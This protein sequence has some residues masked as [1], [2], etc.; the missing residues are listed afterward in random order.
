MAR[1]PVVSNSSAATTAA[2][3]SQQ[4]AISGTSAAGSRVRIAPAFASSH[5]KKSASAITP[6]LTT[7]ASPPANSRSGS[8]FSTSG[9]I[10]TPAGWWKAPARFLPRGRF[11]PVLPP[12]DESAIASR[13]VGT[14]IRAIP[15][16]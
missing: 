6:Y 2:F 11:T 3:S 1:T 16:M 7:S 8:E 14:W 10:S 9:S 5:A 15:R 4:R 12:T 13:L